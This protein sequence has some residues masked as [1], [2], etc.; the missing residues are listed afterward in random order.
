MNKEPEEAK[1]REGVNLLIAT[2]GRLIDH[3]RYTKGF[4]YKVPFVIPFLI[5]ITFLTSIRIYDV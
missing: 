2:P 3:L 1:L 4:K 5:T